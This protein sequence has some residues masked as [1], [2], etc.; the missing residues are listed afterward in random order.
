MSDLTVREG[1]GNAKRTGYWEVDD[2]VTP[3]RNLFG[4]IR[5]HVGEVYSWE[6]QRRVHDRRL[7]V[8]S[9]LETIAHSKDVFLPTFDDALA[10]LTAAWP[11]AGSS[12]SLELVDE[13]AAGT[14]PGMD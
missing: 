4:T 1:D 11:A 8:G 13:P 3:A 10:A 9:R 6:I 14:W 12:T 5:L 7:R 2:G